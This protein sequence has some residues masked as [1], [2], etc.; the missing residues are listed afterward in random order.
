M[1]TTTDTLGHGYAVTI[2][3]MVEELREW[4]SQLDEKA[5]YTEPPSGEWT[6]MKSLVHVVEFLPYWSEQL[7]RV[8]AAPGE[9]FGR[10]HEDPERI[11]SVEN[12]AHDHL[13]PVLASL[14]AAATQACQQIS[15][16][17]DSE[18]VTTGVHRR[19]VMSLHEI[20]DFFLLTHLAEHTAQ[21]KAAADGVEGSGDTRN[22]G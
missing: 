9:P 14:A 18:W 7:H 3:E 5:L 4:A 10:T 22:G 20:V 15:R 6:V 8:S 21:A 1:N 19:G 13:R 17:P 2:A 11:A 16:I 12:H